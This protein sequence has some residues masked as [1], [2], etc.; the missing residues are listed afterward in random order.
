[1][2]VQMVLPE[3]KVQMGIEISKAEGNREV[4]VVAPLVRV[5][6]GVEAMVDKN[7]VL[8]TV[9]RRVLGQAEVLVVLG[10]VDR[11]PRVGRVVMVPM[12]VLE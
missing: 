2:Q 10:V 8:E 3:A 11:A 5:L 12:V 1:M 7:V 9:A 6:G 4:L